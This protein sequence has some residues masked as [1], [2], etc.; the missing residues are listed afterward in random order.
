MTN[1]L[2]DLQT[3]AV[4]L[5]NLKPLENNP[6][7]GDVDAVVASYTRF[8]QR[9]PIVARKQGREKSGHPQGVILAGNHQYE[10]AKAL[11]W[12]EIAVVWVS[13]DDDTARAYAVADNRTGMMGGWDVEA[14]AL[15]LDGLADD[16]LIATGF[17]TD[18][19]DNLTAQLEEASTT[20]VIDPAPGQPGRPGTDD[21]GT[22]MT[23]SLT[24]YAERYAQATTRV[25]MCDYSNEQYVWLIERLG[26]I[27]MDL[28]LTSN[29]EAILVMIQQ[30]F[31][32]N[33]PGQP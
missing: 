30:Y 9:K 11:G 26:R 28:D 27:R 32:E 33:P 5:A 16:L 20:I 6:R 24:D 1:I 13:D 14:L 4:P 21:N 23:P 8:G 25:L 2:P 29:A 31:Q 22:R 3:L 18:D 10:A 19:L 15:S 12:D 17:T 7:K